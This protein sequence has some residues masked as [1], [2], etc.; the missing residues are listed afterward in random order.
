M[1][2]IFGRLAIAF[3]G[4]AQLVKLTWMFKSIHLNIMDFHRSYMSMINPDSNTI[5]TC[6]IEDGG[7]APQV[8]LS[9]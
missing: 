9:F 8:L 2:D 5:Y 1:S 4:K 3:K 7:E 6:T